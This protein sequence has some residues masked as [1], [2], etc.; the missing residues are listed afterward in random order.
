MTEQWVFHFDPDSCIGC[1]AC[2]TACKERNGV[3]PADDSERTDGPDWRRVIHVSDGTFTVEDIEQGRLPDYEETSVSMSCMHCANP[4]CEKVCPTNAIEKR[5]TDGIVTVD[6][7][8]CIGC[9]YC[10]WACPYGAPQY[11][12]DGFMQKCNLCLSS[13]AAA[14]GEPRHHPDDGG[15]TPACVETCVGAALDAG[16]VSEMMRKASEEAAERFA[17]RDNASVIV[18]RA[19]V[20]SN[21][22][23][24]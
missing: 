21:L 2:A 7:D 17:N 1:Q 16:P 14:S 9:H 5:D 20:E 18:E 10:G 23:G 15:E 13:E 4:P 22:L 19:G 6:Q 24:R 11:G 3:A 8:E 12:D